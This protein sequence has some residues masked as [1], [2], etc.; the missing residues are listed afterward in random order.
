MKLSIKTRILFALYGSEYMEAFRLD[1]ML[2]AFTDEKMHDINRVEKHPKEFERIIAKLVRDEY[3][4]NSCGY[5][6]EITSEGLLFYAKGGYTGQYLSA[7]RT[8]CSF[9]ISVISA[10]IAIASFFISICY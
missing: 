8:N 6:Y 5:Y 7:K 3:I 9:W 10:I 2:N 1:S 4:K